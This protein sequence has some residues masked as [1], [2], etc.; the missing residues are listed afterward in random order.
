MNSNLFLRVISAIVLAPLVL[1]AIWYGKAIYEDYSIPVYKILLAV[2]GAGLA[3]EWENMFRKKISA[4]GLVISLTATLSVFLIEDNPSFALWLILLGTTVVYWLSKYNLSM[5]FGT[6]YISLPLAALGYIYYVNESIS[7]EIVLWLFFVVWATDTGGYIVGSSL[8]GPKILPKISPKKTWSGCIGGVVFAMAVAYVFSLYLKAHNLITP[9][10][11]LYDLLTPVLVASAAVLS[12][13]SIAGDFFESYVKRRL[14][15]KDSS[16]LIPGH[17][18]LFDRVDGLLFAAVVA[19]IAI[20][21]ANTG[22]VF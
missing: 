6:L 21:L 9:A 16:N 5:T 17:G 12:V 11:A 13:F 20:F 10:D 2:L 19:A 8:K 4:V 14:D 15:I 18:G 3:W 22:G 1:C 7:R